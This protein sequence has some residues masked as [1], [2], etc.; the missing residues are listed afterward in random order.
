[1]TA[2]VRRALAADAEAMRQIA[3]AAYAIYQPRLN[4]APAPVTADYPRLVAEHDCWVVELDG[5]I[6]GFV[7]LVVR[8]DHLLLE[9]IAVSPGHQRA[10]IGAT[11]LDLAD[12]RARDLGRGEVRLYTN[13]VMTENQAYYPRHGYVET[14][15]A[16]DDGYQRVFFTKRVDA[17]ALG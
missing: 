15:R 17:A 5:V 8:P 16:E 9:N 12:D 7:V 13:E 2:V 1:M 4:R 6:A 10:G 11:L 3:L 14:H